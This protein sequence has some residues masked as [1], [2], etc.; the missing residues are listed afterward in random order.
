MKAWI[1]TDLAT[2]NI[3]TTRQGRVNTYFK[4]PTVG[5]MQ[6]M[7]RNLK[8]KLSITEIEINVSKDGASNADN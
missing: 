5:N 6:S 2:G 4:I 3:V 8:R 7:E 1:Y